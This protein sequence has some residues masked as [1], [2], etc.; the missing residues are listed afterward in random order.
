[1]KRTQSE[2]LTVDALDERTLPFCATRD[3]PAPLFT[4]EALYENSIQSIDLE[5]YRGSWVILF[6]YAS[7]FTFV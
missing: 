7:D 4:A 1:M 2:F 5:D 3:D 6:F